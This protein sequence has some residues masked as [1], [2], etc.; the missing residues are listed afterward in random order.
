M[1]VN[2]NQGQ[3]IIRILLDDFASCLVINKALTVNWPDCRGSV[4][5]YYAIS[6]YSDE[7]REKLTSELNTVLIDGNENDILKSVSTF[8][9]L[10]SNGEYEIHFYELKIKKHSFFGQDQLI[11]S[12]T[13]PDNEKFYGSFYPSFFDS[14]NIFY[15]ISNNKMNPERIDFYTELIR[16]GIRP[17]ILLFESCK[18]LDNSSSTYILDGHHKLEAY[19]KLGIDIPAVKIVKKETEY[20]ATE[21]ILNYIH[22]IVKDFEFNH[23]I[24]NNENIENIAFQSNPVFTKAID[25]ILLNDKNIGVT[26]IKLMINIA[27]K[28]NELDNEWINDRLNI[29]KSNKNIGK[30]FYLYYNII[31][32]GWFPFEINTVNDLKKWATEVLK[33]NWTFE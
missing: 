14:H 10:F 30:G 8:L 28:G 6:N 21:E 4:G 25:S 19:L 20:S 12:E 3:N 5:E 23:F 1:Q 16:Q 24:K 2:V 32:K 13:T 27:A 29:L 33:R 9:N 18:D 26:I 15:T 22:P 17:K 7:E 31:N 11:Y